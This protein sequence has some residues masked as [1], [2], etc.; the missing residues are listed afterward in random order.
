M[1][2]AANNPPE[3]VL[4]RPGDIFGGGLGSRRVGLF[5]RLLLVSRWIRYQRLI[6]LGAEGLAGIPTCR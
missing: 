5:D 3:P 4:S 6:F 2:Q 1:K